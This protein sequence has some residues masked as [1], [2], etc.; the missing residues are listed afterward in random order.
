MILDEATASLDSLTER[1]VMESVRRLA[2]RDNITTII[3]AHRLVVAWEKTSLFDCLSRA[4]CQLWQTVTTSWFW[5]RD[6]WW[7]RG[8]IVIFYLREG[9]TGRCGPGNRGRRSTTWSRTETTPD[10]Y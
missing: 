3:I 2:E 5:S 6:E 4:G 9:D 10:L 8:H 1:R 7:R